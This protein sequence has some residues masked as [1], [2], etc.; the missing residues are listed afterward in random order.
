[1]QRD[2]PTPHEAGAALAEEN[3]LLREFVDTSRDA[4]WCIEF[5]EPVDLTAPGHEVIRQ[6]FDN[7]CIW[8][9][10]NPAMARLYGLPGDVDFNAQNVRF[11]FDRN[12]DNENFV[13]TLLASNFHVDG[14]MSLDR[15]FAG[16]HVAMENDVRGYIVDGRLHRMM[17]AVRNLSPQLSRE[18]ALEARVATLS[19]VLGA[20]PDPVV[21]IDADGIV[22]AVGPALAWQLGWPV[23]DVLGRPV[24][25]LVHN[26]RHIAA[27]ADTMGPGTPAVDVAAQ[28]Q[29]PGQHV[30]ECA[31]HV[32]ACEDAAGAP[33]YVLVLRVDGARGTPGTTP[34]PAGAG[35]RAR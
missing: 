27:L 34:A 11:F 7:E 18:R 14:V 21:V 9:M 12:P 3:A 16:R 33:C 6:V 19:N 22:D 30:F 24:E 35:R 1:M 17:G 10:C 15:D 5:I 28:V 20:L 31:A 2:H 25:R 23:D 4:L 32:A 13:R 29:M 26:W 8:R